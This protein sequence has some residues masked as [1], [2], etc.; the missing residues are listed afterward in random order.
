MT[1]TNHTQNVL[2]ICMVLFHKPPI[3]HI[4][5]KNYRTYSTFPKTK[6][7]QHTQNIPDT[8]YFLHHSSLGERQQS[9]TVDIFQESCN[10]Y[11]GDSTE[12]C[13]RQALHHVHAG[14][15][16]CF[17]CCTLGSGMRQNS[18]LVTNNA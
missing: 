7:T 5:P 13:C 4:Y 11:T 6:H 18:V 17:L 2:D 10:V 3:T 14:L 12:G 1:H 16:N 9:E 8:R 15:L